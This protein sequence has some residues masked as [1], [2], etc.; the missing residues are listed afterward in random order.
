M[1]IGV[2]YICTGKYSIFWRDF[3]ESS[4][5]YFLPEDDKE[6]FVFTDAD[7]IEGEGTEQIHKIFQENLGWPDNT[8]MRFRMFNSI[9]DQLKQ[10]D[11]LFFFNANLLFIKM[12]NR[13]FL[14]V[15]ENLSVVIHPGFRDNLPDEFP[16]ERNDKS[17][18]YIPYGMGTIYIQGALN[19]GKTAAY[20]EMIKTLDENVLKDKAN[21]IIA[22]WH[23]ES[24]LNHY[25]LNRSDLKI[26]GPEY[27]NQ[28]DKN[29]GIQPMIVSRNKS[30]YMDIDE[31]RGIKRS[32]VEKSLIIVKKAIKKAIGRS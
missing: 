5:K 20:L 23:D 16:Y 30:R 22:I 4:E 18:A 19:G 26:L 31:L 12:I 13:D 32:F 24:H 1:K 10:M 14:P 25:I 2:L 9:A 15:E 7:Y 17:L 8:L 11:Y 21:N 28:E 3:Y 27:V 29:Y 6:Y